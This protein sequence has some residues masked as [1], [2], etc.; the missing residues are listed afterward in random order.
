MCIISDL[1]LGIFLI[2]GISFDNANLIK[3]SLILLIIDLTLRSIINRLNKRKKE[4]EKKL[5]DIIGGK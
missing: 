5:S 1:A 4:L 2:I 3:L